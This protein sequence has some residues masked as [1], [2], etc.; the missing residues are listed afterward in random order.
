MTMPVNFTTVGAC[1][2][3]G[4]LGAISF[5]DLVTRIKDGT[6]QIRHLRAISDESEQK[7]YKNHNLTLWAPSVTFDGK[8]EQKSITGY[9]ALIKFDFDAKDNPGV[10]PAALRDRLSEHPSVVLASVSV[11]GGGVNGACLVDPSPV[12]VASHKR[13][14]HL[15]RAMLEEWT[16]AKADDMSD[17]ARC[18]VISHDPDVYVNEHPDPWRV[19]VAKAKPT[20]AERT[21]KTALDLLSDAKAG[22]TYKART[23]AAMLLGG[24]GLSDD[25]P[26]VQ[27]ALRRVREAS[28]HPDD[29][30]AD[31]LKAMEAGRRK[32]IK[33]EKKTADQA[34]LEHVRVL[35]STTTWWATAAYGVGRD[36]AEFYQWT[37]ERWEHRTAQE[38]ASALRI[39]DES[40]EFKNKCL[41]YLST[42]A[43]VQGVADQDDLGFKLALVNGVLDFQDGTFRKARPEDKLRNTIGRRYLFP[44]ERLDPGKN[45][46][47]LVLSAYAPKVQKIVVY[48]L[49]PRMVAPWAG[50]KIFY[51]VGPAG[52]GKSKLI[53]LLCRLL[54]GATASLPAD[55]LR[56][57]QFQSKRLEGVL[58]NLTAESRRSEIK[59]SEEWKEDA[60][61]LFF[62]V[63]IK[64]GDIYSARYMA[65]TV[66]ACNLMPYLPGL[67]SEYWRR[68]FPIPF[69]TRLKGTEAGSDD[70][71][72]IIREL[73]DEELDS[74]F[75][76][77]VDVAVHC[78][79]EG[80]Y[81][82]DLD[83][84]TTE[85]LYLDLVDGL[86][87]FMQSRLKWSDSGEH[88]TLADIVDAYRVSDYSLVDR[89]K[90]RRDERGTYT[91]FELARTIG[92]TMGGRAG[93]VKVPHGDGPQAIL[94]LTWAGTD[95]GQASRIGDFLPENRESQDGYCQLK[96]SMGENPICDGGFPLNMP[97]SSLT[98]PAREKE[99]DEERENLKKQNAKLL[100]TR[101]VLAENGTFHGK[102][103]ID[104]GKSSPETVSEIGQSNKLGDPKEVQ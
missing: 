61:R 37:G 69:L 85:A 91:L 67:G 88:V 38:I 33:E 84:D 96:N 12:D 56:K 62:E 58:A 39:V 54:G 90:G 20:K 64:G 28:A 70:I 30:E 3:P 27:E 4:D 49:I 10:D 71:E 86:R 57:S 73:T 35:L 44:H 104:Q 103:H 74:V 32:P 14:E 93:Q 23:D 45:R 1:S 17:P 83:D 75:S 42:L 18:L 101:V 95:R 41:G 16:G 40:M 43:Q 13:I 19:P 92:V 76:E 99:R 46:F 100:P 82:G 66:R 6:P 31:F 51:L 25:A 9:T 5:S 29:A 77:A 79:P 87:L 89:E 48:A 11:R 78:G 55:R 80:T 22:G 50:G 94:G 72:R 26:E 21:I 81:P 63:E 15:V 98:T 53:S 24:V 47:F 65:T 36:R 7:N 8:R 68:L 97:F 2:A 102:T 34:A 60:D 52:T 59:D